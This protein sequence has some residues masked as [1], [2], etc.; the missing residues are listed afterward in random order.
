MNFLNVSHVA[1][2]LNEKYQ[3]CN[4]ELFLLKLFFVIWEER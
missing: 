1:C 2:I 3:T 4:L